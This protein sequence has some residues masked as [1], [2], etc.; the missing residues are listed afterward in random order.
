MEILRKLNGK[1][2]ALF[3]SRWINKYSVAA[4][5]FFTWL[6]FFDRHN[7]VTQWKLRKTV[8]ELEESRK[9]YERLLAIALE[10]KGN[11]EKNKEKYAREKYYMHKADEDVY[12]I[13]RD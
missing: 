2:S 6:V 9:E 12:I 8:S 1:V 5:L 10:E 11:L 13:D 3:R 7:L 4:F